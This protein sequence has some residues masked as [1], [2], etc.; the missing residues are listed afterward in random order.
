MI[1]CFF[2]EAFFFGGGAADTFGCVTSLFF[3]AR[4]MCGGDGAAGGGVGA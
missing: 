3:H 4:A 2:L 1:G